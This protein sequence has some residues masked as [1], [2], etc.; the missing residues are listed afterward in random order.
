MKVIQK[1]KKAFFEYE[2]LDK[3]IAGMI[4]R[5]WQVKS[6]KAGKGSFNSPY[7]VFQKGELYLKGIQ[8]AKW[9]GMNDYDYKIAPEE[10]KLL[11][12]EEEINKLKRKLETKGNTIIPLVIGIE[13]GFL[14]VE[15]AVARGKKQYDKRS[16]MKE[17]DQK[18][19]IDRELKQQRFF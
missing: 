2:I 7:C 11:L 5:G 12:H 16:K 14:K 1:N 19:S 15:I 10:V 13:R 4:L 3:Y 9:P 6:I 8:I 17:R 18:R